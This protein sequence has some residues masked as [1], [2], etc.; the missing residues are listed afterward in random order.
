MK[1]EKNYKTSELITIKE[2]AK[3][4]KISRNTVNYLIDKHLLTS[5]K[6]GYARFIVNDNK[7]KIYTKSK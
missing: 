6:Q 4:K 7:A 3:M 2:F 5:T 1:P